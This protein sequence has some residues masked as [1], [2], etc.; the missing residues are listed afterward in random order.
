MS[1]APKNIWVNYDEKTMGMEFPELYPFAFDPGVEYIRKD[2][3][4]EL[5]VTSARFKLAADNSQNKL[6]T[7]IKK[8]EDA[9]RFY[10]NRK[11]G[12]T[13]RNALEKEVD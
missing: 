2:V 5:D 13:A 6:G 12:T 9:L 11:D 7:R 1:E 10:A 3:Y 8:L 4:D